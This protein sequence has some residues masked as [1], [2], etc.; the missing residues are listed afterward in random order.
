M[1]LR[2]ESNS[3]F[4]LKKGLYLNVISTTYTIAFGKTYIDMQNISDDNIHL[5]YQRSTKVSSKT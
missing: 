2:G 3:P 5:T 4:L 1:M